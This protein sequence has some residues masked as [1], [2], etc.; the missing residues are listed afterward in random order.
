MKI[1]NLALAMGTT[2]ALLAALLEQSLALSFTH[3]LQLQ[4]E[5]P[6]EMEISRIALIASY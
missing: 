4:E 6:R 3:S 1:M 2:S 5:L